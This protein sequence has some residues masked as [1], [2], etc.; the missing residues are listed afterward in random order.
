MQSSKMQLNYLYGNPL[1]A[2]AAQKK[3]R[4]NSRKNPLSAAE[5]RNLLNDLEA[6]REESD[7]EKR[8][9]KTKK[10][11][12]ASTTSGEKKMAE[13][14]TST[15]KK[16]A[17]KKVAKKAA[18]KV[19][20]KLA[21]KTAKKVAKKTAKKVVRKVAKKV[22]KRKVAKRKVA[23]S[24]SAVG[25]KIVRRGKKFKRVGRSE[26]GVVQ[27][28][29]TK[30]SNNARKLKKGQSL[31]EIVEYAPKRRKTKKGIKMGAPKRKKVTIVALN[32]KRRKSRKGRNPIIQSNPRFMKNPIGAIVGMEN[33]LL[34][35]GLFKKADSMT[36]KFLNIG[37]LEVAGLAVGSAFDG[38]IVKGFD[39]VAGKVPMMGEMMAKIPAKYKAPALTGLTGVGL[40]LL[41]SFLAKKS[42]KK[43]QVLDELSR[44]LIA[45]ALVKGVASMSKFS[46]ENSASMS[47]Y[48]ESMGGT[49]F[50]PHSMNG[51]VMS[52]PSMGGYVMSNPSASMPVG[53]SDFSGAD[54]EGADYGTSSIGGADFEGMLENSMDAEDY[55]SDVHAVSGLVF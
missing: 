17:K 20:K 30:L 14:K 6:F 39:F 4:L 13:K 43:S 41:N 28:R 10:A 7:A 40:H 27:G 33:K 47:G 48:V 54:F 15:K 11:K 22:A 51:Y 18:A 44:G 31:T 3:S 2:K 45:S 1:R 25:G 52:N 23:R 55:G 50:A 19:V 49:V 34:N 21:K 37:V 32:P 26:S 46:V 42:G 29:F 38:H 5:K 9:N 36:K 53:N 24:M 16:V 8:K 12:S 35:A